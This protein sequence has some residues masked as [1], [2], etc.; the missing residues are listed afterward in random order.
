[1]ALASVGLPLMLAH[2][3]VLML[4]P[5][6]AMST[7]PDNAVLAASAAQTAVFLAAGVWLSGYGHYE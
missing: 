7:Q 6:I 5:A 1:M 3:F 2:P 4:K